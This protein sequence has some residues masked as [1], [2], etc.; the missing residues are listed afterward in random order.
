[1]DQVPVDLQRWRGR[2][3]LLTERDRYLVNSSS[4][5]RRIARWTS[6]QYSLQL[7]LLKCFQSP[8]M[9]DS[10]DSEPASLQHRAVHH[11]HD[12]H[13]VHDLGPHGHLSHD[14]D[15][16]F[17]TWTWGSVRCR[18]IPWGWL[19]CPAGRRMLSAWNWTQWL[20]FWK[21]ITK[22]RTRIVKKLLNLIISNFIM[23]CL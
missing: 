9:F 16:L 8:D 6:S 5:G 10:W 14:P 4:T 1:M 17:L 12:Q 2:R 11:H 7:A 18:T 21:S 19:S 3:I 15:L 13:A 20:S 22:L 23:L